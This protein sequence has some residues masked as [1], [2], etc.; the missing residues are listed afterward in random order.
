MLRSAAVS[1]YGLLDAGTP[2]LWSVSATK[3]RSGR[4]GCNANK[5]EEKRKRT[6][7][8]SFCIGRSVVQLSLSWSFVSAG[9][10]SLFSA[11][12]AAAAIVLFFYVGVASVSVAKFQLLRSHSV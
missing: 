9:A 4:F 3:C 5:K 11:A 8:T 2:L 12:A 6:Q 7:E 10:I 1:A